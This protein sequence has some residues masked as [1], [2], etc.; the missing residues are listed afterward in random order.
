MATIIIQIQEISSQ[1]PV[2][3]EGKA[4]C[5]TTNAKKTNRTHTTTVSAAGGH[6]SNTSVRMRHAAKLNA[7]MNELLVT[8][9]RGLTA[10]DIARVAADDCDSDMPMVLRRA[11]VARGSE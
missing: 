9:T 8:C 1:N 3:V 5:F 4:N 10:S 2:V 11:E 7:S 6:A